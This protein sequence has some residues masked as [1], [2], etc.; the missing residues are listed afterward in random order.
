MIHS[1]SAF[2]T[3]AYLKIKS[4]HLVEKDMS[5]VPVM[6]F[7]NIPLDSAALN[8]RD[9]V[10]G[11]ELGTPTP[12]WSAGDYGGTITGAEENPVLPSVTRRGQWV[13]VNSAQ[14]PRTPFQS[15]Q[16]EV[17]ACFGVVRGNHALLTMSGSLHHSRFAFSGRLRPHSHCEYKPLDF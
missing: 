5:A 16:D 8:I 1:D 4:A 10:R 12:S 9:V 2:A 14:A 6:Q 17:K 15:L 11:V 13:A 7:T 3:V